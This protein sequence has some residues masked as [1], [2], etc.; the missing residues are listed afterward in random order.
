MLKRQG[1]VNVAIN[2]PATAEITR[3]SK[4]GA[5]GILNTLLDFILYNALSTLAGLSLVRSNIISTSIAMT[6]SFAANKQVVFQKNNGSVTKQAVLFFTIT[7]IGLYIIQTGTI[8]IL[9][10]IW[11]AP[12][13][14]VLAAAHAMNIVGHDQFI[15]KNGA[16]AIATVLS[17]TWNYIMYKKVV[18]S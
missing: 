18:F 5:V 17:M 4:F 16:K 6:F 14:L 8:K 12:M 11:L 9:T 10:D 15:A 13:T 2:K 7:A 3:V 1:E